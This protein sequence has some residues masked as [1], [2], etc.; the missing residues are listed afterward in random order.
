MIPAIAPIQAAGIDAVPALAPQVL[1]G[2]H[3]SFADLLINGVNAVEAKLSSA[4]A[5]AKAF[6]FDDSV[7][8]H[9]VTYALEEARL[10]LELMMQVRGRLVEAYQQL[11]GM[12]L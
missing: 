12:Q 3:G 8:V 9:Q 7:P 4:D 1:P 11:M 5:A 6:V 10:S 2:A